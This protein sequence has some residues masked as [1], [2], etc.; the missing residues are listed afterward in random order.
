MSRNLVFVFV[1]IL[2]LFFVVTMSKAHDLNY[3]IIVVYGSTPTIDGTIDTFE[4]SDAASVFFNKTEVL[5]KQDG[6]S[7]Y[8]GFNISYT[9]ADL[10]YD[11]VYVFLDLDDNGGLT[12]QPDDIALVVYNNGTLVQACGRLS[13]TSRIQ[14]SR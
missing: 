6:V 2:F 4:W 14:K 3:E 7:L 10:K 13:S 5:V 9:P 11:A 8:V 1:A 12:L